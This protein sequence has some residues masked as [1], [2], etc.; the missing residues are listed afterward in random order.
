MLTGRERA[1]RYLTSSVSQFPGAAAFGLALQESGFE[2]VTWKS[3][4]GGI[5][6]I[7]TGLA[8]AAGRAAGTGARSD[9]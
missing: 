6:C 7:H 9:A 3:L 8:G 1:Y 2:R 4:T 5:V